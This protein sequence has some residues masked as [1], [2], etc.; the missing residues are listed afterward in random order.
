MELIDNGLPQAL[1]KMSFTVTVSEDELTEHERDMV[2]LGLETGKTS[3]V[4][5]AFAAASSRNGQ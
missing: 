4:L 5:Q 2:R 3:I 1:R